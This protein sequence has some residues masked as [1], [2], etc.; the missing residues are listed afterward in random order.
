MSKKN[1]YRVVREHEGDRFYSVG[2]TRTAIPSEVK[3]LI[4]HVLEEIGASSE[5]DDKP[6]TEEKAEPAPKNKA[7]GAAP[8]NKSTKSPV[9]ETKGE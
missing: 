6:I 2:D 9:R 3:H 5:Q 4:P 1:D 7:E 8:S